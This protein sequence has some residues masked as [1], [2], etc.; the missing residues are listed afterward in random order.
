MSSILSIGITGLKAAQNGIATATHNI[1]NAA[2]PGYSRQE[3]VLATRMPT[4][5]GEGFL[6]QGVQVTTVRRIYNDFLASQV[7]D[8]QAAASQLD[9]QYRHIK[10]IDNLLADSTAGLSPAMQGFFNSVQVVA[11]NPA[12]PASR[13]VMLSASNALDGRFQMLNTHLGGIRSDVESGIRVSVDAINTQTTQLARLNEQIATAES[14][15]YGH[16]ANDLRDQRDLLLADLNKE[17]KTTA[18]RMADGTVNVYAV[19]G[20]ALVLGSQSARLTAQPSEADR[21]QLTIAYEMGGIAQPLREADITGGRL[22]GLVAF[23]AGALDTAQNALGRMAAGLALSFNAQ[24]RLGQNLAGQMGGDYF[25]L[26]PAYAASHAANTGNAQIAASFT[27]AAA[28]VASDYQIDYDGSNYTVTRLSDGAVQ[29]AASLPATVDGLQL[30][31]QSGSLAAGD[32]FLLRP[33]REAASSLGLA[34][35]DPASIAAAAPVRGGAAAGN[36]GSGVISTGSVDASYPATPLFAPLMISFDSLAG[37]LSGFPAASSVVVESNG[38]Q[39]T[40]APGAPVP[41]TP[42]ATLRFNGMAFSLSGNP[43]NGDQFIIQP[44]VGGTGDNRNAL[45]LA[46]LQTRAVLAGGTTG[47]TDAYGQLLSD[48][49]SRTR[50]L[51]VASGMQG[52]LLEEANQSQQ[53]FSGVNLDEEAARLM[54]YQQAYQASAKVMQMASEMFETLLSIRR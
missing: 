14:M 27:D 40:Y 19:N 37:T 15:A 26:P 39:T 45:L 28:L 3:G 33:Y 34:I 52:K 24:H 9:T 7:R 38:A 6:G 53:S 8:A 48:I 23:R 41:Y 54:R 25:S 47:L 31:L 18:I 22:G 35:R 2:T 5:T 46:G 42:G 30:A 20:Q 49:G 51:E 13:Q 36:H 21:T 44:N 12:D 11:N 16:Q 4:A 1:S 29:T 50:E 43:A 10:R 17:L 32:R